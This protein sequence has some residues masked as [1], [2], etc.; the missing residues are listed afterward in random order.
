MHEYRFLSPTP[1]VESKRIF[2]ELSARRLSSF[3]FSK[4]WA[5]RGY[6]VVLV[7]VSDCQNC[8]QKSSLYIDDIR[9]TFFWL[10]CSECNGAFNA[11]NI[12]LLTKMHVWS[13]CWLKPQK[14][15]WLVLKLKEKEFPLDSALTL[16]M[17]QSNHL[18]T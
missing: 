13:S 10:F 15:R 2:S 16:G 7:S 9:K 12:K 18:M 6:H 3:Y 8:S 4:F 17:A 11:T 1:G 5:R 14:G